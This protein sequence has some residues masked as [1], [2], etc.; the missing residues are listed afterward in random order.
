MPQ[1]QRRDAEIAKVRKGTQREL[2]VSDQFDFIEMLSLRRRDFVG[3]FCLNFALK[4][5]LK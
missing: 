4:C 2:V 1:A 3:A 5:F